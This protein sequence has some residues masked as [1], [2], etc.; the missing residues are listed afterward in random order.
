MYFSLNMTD[1]FKLSAQGVKTMAMQKCTDCGKQ[2]SNQAKQCPQCGA[3]V[4]RKKG[5]LGTVAV[6]FIIGFFIWIIAASGGDKQKTPQPSQVTE[7]KT[8]PLPPVSTTQVRAS[9]AVQTTPKITPKVEPTVGMAAPNWETRRTELHSKYLREF[10]A[11]RV[12]SNVALQ[13]ATGN[14][15]RGILKELKQDSIQI[16]SGPATMAFTKSQLSS[17]TCLRC[18]AEDYACLEA[19]KHVQREKSQF[20]IKQ[21]ENNARI[22]AEQER[23]AKEE[24]SNAEKLKAQ[25]RVSKAK[26]VL[27]NWSWS[28][29]H[30]YVTV[31][32][33]V[34]NI[35]G[36][37]F[38][39]VEA[40]V[41]FYTEDKK[42]IKSDSA[43]IEYNP[44][45][46]GQISPFKVI[47]THNPLIKAANINFKIM[48]G[49]SLD[50][51][52]KEEYDKAKH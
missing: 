46:P 19:D 38:Q 20:E 27:V 21:N 52:R 2:I 37:K 14:T 23:I 40:L 34:G 6:I 44:I 26:L 31:E 36:Q 50:F 42:F 5:C 15:V 25:E 41:E 48:F 18:F 29:E 49:Q 8:A 22:L 9:T 47:T 13:L 24:R 28:S 11:P 7:S 45:M 17:E 10:V 51:V 16:Q 32:G 1:A 39:N 35:S 3:P 4:K 12:G 33:Q 30:G 43:L